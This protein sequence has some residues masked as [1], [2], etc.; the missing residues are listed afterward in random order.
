[1]TQYRCSREDKDMKEALKAMKDSSTDC[2][3]CVRI[4]WQREF[5]C[6]VT[7]V[8]HRDQILEAY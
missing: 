7:S 1:M 4:L 8:R 2:L 6:N 3:E 5:A